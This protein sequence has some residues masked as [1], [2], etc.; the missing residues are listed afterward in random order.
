[1][2]AQSLLEYS[3]LDSLVS[4]ARDLRFWLDDIRSTTWIILAATVLFV[5]F[6]FRYIPR[7]R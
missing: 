5:A 2:V 4:A 3:L 1:M 6:L 7:R